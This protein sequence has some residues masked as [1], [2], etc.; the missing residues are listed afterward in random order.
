MLSSR[1]TRLRRAAAP[2]VGVVCCLLVLPATAAAALTGPVYPVPGTTT[3]G[4]GG[5]VCAQTGTSGG[6]SAGVTW[7][8][9]GG[10]PTAAGE[11]CP[12]STALPP[13][14][15]TNRF[16]KLYWGSN[17]SV[18]KRPQVTMDGAIDSPT[19]TLTFLAGESNLAQGKVVWGGATTMNWCSAASCSTFTNSPVETRLQTTI[20]SVAAGGATGA[21]VVLMT[22]SAAGISNPEVGGV[23]AVTPTLLRFRANIKILARFQGSAAAFQPADEFYNAVH[24]PLVANQYQSHFWD[25]FWYENKPPKA[26]IGFDPSLQ[27]TGT[28]ITFTGK[29][30]DDDGTVKSIAWDFN[31]DGLFTESTVTPAQW[32]FPRAGSFPVRFRVIDNEDAVTVAT[33][34]LKIVDKPAPPPVIT[35]PG[36]GP[37]PV[38][39]QLIP[40]T[41]ANSWLA[42][43][44]Y[45]KATQLSVNN[46]LAA[47]TV[48]VTCKTKKKSQQKKGC[49][50]KKKRFTTS[51]AR[52]KLNLLKPFK[53]KKIPVGAKITISVTVP[54]QIGKRFTYTIR[55][56]KTPK[57]SLRCLPPGGGTSSCA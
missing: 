32:T 44:K 6:S 39:P 47:T 33:K 10:T 7:T 31:N 52:A 13:A 46:L 2:L 38:E 15:N 57:S 56:S 36:P 25:A 18:G 37:G 51:G 4:H 49:P 28:T 11:V 41:V 53:K 54:G 35:P 55:K 34:T 19:E 17:G 30:S 48:N 9:G 45:T 27:T 3:S 8:F 29:N 14:F 24:H 43:P 40:S 23:V 16:A 22:P 42:F 12:A 1:Q 5:S 21:P 20:A 50:Y 26:D